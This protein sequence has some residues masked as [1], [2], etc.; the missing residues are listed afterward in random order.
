VKVKDEKEQNAIT[1]RSVM[2]CFK[3][4]WTNG[5]YKRSSTKGIKFASLVSDDLDQLSI[6]DKKQINRLIS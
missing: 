5:L 4:F 2:R 6:D 1:K 3:F